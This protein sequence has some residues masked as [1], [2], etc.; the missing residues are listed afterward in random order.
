MLQQTCLH[1]LK[2]PGRTFVSALAPLKGELSAL[3]A[4]TE[5]SR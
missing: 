5:G 4:L 2:K 3:K 1:G